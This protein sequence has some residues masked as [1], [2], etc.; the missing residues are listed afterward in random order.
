MNYVQKIRAAVGHQ[1][2]I[3]V[4]GGVLIIDDENRVLLQ[5]RTFPKDTWG[6]PG[7]MME[8]GETT[9]TTATREIEEETGLKLANLKLFT[10]V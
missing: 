1:P 4:V 8:L 7:G 10:F 3:L 6:I 2:I 9:E 5:K